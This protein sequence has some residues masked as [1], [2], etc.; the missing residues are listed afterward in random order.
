MDFFS[1]IT[2]VG[3]VLVLLIL[4]FEYKSRKYYS[5]AE[6]RNSQQRNFRMLAWIAFALLLFTPVFVMQPEETRLIIL[7]TAHIL[8]SFSAIAYW[9]YIFFNPPWHRKPVEE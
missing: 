2:D 3:N 5:K 6:L 4:I 8:V 9:V 7:K 1:I